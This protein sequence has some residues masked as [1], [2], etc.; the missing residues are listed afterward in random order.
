[1]PYF[2]LCIGAVF[3]ANS[4]V[5]DRTFIS[6]GSASLHEEMHVAAEEVKEAMTMTLKRGWTK[7]YRIASSHCT[8]TGRNV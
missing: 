8:A 5:D 3:S 4:E 6:D 1:M 2:S 7:A